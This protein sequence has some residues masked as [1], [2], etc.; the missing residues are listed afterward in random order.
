MPLRPLT[1]RVPAT[2]ANLGPGFDGLGMALKLFNVFQITPLAKGPNR[3]G[4]TGTCEGLK[5]SENVFFSAYRRV[6]AAAK[7]NPPPLAVE[8]RG[9]VP[10]SRGLGSSATAIVA[11]AMTA[12]AWLE[13]RFTNDELLALM[14][15]EEG[16]PDNVAP[17]FL[18]GLTAAMR[19]DS[20]VLALRAKPHRA[21][22]VALLVPDYPLSTE[23]ARRAIP[24]MIPHRDAVFNLTRVP[25]VF[26]ALTSGKQAQLNLALEDRLHEPYRKKFI[27]GYDAIR[28]AAKKAGA[29]AVYLSGAGP[30]MAA[31]C[32]GEAKAQEVS[33]AMRTAVR[34]MNFSA[35]AM[36][37]KPH[38][39]AAI[40]R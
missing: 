11:G 33:A 2:T 24:K 4:G 31:F 20:R 30:T 6:F 12:N 36:I 28:F 15:E 14:T 16:H 17:A 29:S 38:L 25:L 35:E 18:G 9:N 13:N 8:V 7:K 26:D 40:I 19:T 39:D 23:K 10:M 3:I 27:K 5:G 1:I 34:G 22:R 21:W 37:L 32:W